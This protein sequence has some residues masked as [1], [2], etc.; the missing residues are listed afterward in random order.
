MEKKKRKTNNGRKI[1][2]R[3]IL[4]KKKTDQSGIER[5]KNN[6]REEKKSIITKLISSRRRQKGEHIKK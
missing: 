2:L 1:E 6:Q 3:R 5:L 4:G